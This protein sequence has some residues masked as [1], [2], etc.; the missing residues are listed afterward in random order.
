AKDATKKSYAPYSN[1]R[2]GAALLTEAGNCYQGC[3][4]ENASYGLTI[5]AERVAI[6]NAIIHESDKLRIKV[7]AI[8]NDKELPCSPCGS[9]RQ[10]IYEFGADSIVIF[11]EKNKFLQISIQNLLPFS[12][13]FTE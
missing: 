9:C 13:S 1:F 10:F 7:I 4:I 5:C 6:S 3:N 8:V 12:F 2:V 11:K